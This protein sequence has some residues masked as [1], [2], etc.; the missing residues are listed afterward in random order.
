MA[1]GVPSHT[2]AVGAIIPSAT[3]G[4][5][6][7]DSLTALNAGFSVPLFPTTTGIVPASRLAG[8]RFSTVQSSG[9]GTP[10][11]EWPILSFSAGTAE[12][13]IWNGTVHRLY[14]STMTIS[15]MFY[16]ATATSGSVVLDARVACWSDADASVTAKVFAAVNT[17]TVTVPGTAGV[18]KAFSITMTN[19]DSAAAV[20]AFSVAF[21]REAL[22]AGGDLQLK[23]LDVFFNIS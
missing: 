19:A 12:G 8:A 20:D 9:A 23:R 10:T 22:G 4:I 11:P 15:G 21:Y 3:Y 6:V 17:T 14:A 1:Y 18:M 13:R 7:K 2:P 16:M 5:P